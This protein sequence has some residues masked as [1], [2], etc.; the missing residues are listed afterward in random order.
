MLTK[1]YTTHGVEDDDGVLGDELAAVGEVLG[2]QMGGA[3]PEGV[4]HTFDFLMLI[5][6][7]SLP[8]CRE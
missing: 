3:K 2:A 7:Y 5:S 4:V 8:L 6:T 1:I